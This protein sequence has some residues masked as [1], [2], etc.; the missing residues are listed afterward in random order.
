MG[1]GISLIG[2]WIT[3][4]ASIW[5]V[6]RLTHSALL[7]GLVGFASQFPSFF[8]S[9]FAGIFVDRWNRHRIL[10]ITQVLSMFQSLALAWLALTGV[11]SIYQIII[12][13]VFQGLVNAFDVPARQ[14]F[15]TEMVEKKEYLGNAIALN[16]SLFN[17]AR[18]IGPAI[19]GLL[20]AAV[21]EGICFLID[22]VSYIAV[23]YSLLAMQ[24]KPRKIAPTNSRPWQQLKDG[25]VYAFGF[26]PIRA[27]LFLLALVSFVAMPYTI[28]V[29]VFATEILHGNSQ[30]LGFLMAGSGLGAFCGAIYL[31]SRQT[32][33]G[34]GKIIA[35]APAILG[36]GLIGFSLSRNFWFS[37]LMMPVI[38]CGIIL[39]V[40][41][42]NTLL[43]TI[44]EDDKRGR[45]MS[46]FTMSFMGTVP[47]G[48]LAGG[49]LAHYIGAPNTLTLGGICC[50][51]GAFIFAKQLPRLKPFILPIYTNLGIIP[52][53]PSPEVPESKQNIS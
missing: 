36:I 5:L 53:K 8:M 4:V 42:S 33:R 49:T 24:L 45:V 9:P 23:I 13:S 29:P 34:L 48:N 15:V 19:A 32:V 43:Q 17:G 1:Q 11:I 27:I 26:P 16:S 39:Q 52:E 6:Y 18:L 28:L 3:Q 38:G 21:G 35:F 12:L 41:S 40:A 10:I 2:T 22:S 20:L 46:L 14:S 30:T 7:L 51:I 37:F 25:F 44:V 50:M 47:L 31:S